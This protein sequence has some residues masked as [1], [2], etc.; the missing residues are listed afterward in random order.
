MSRTARARIVAGSLITLGFIALT[1]STAVAWPPPKTTAAGG[2]CTGQGTRTPIVWTIHNRETAN[3]G[4]PATVSGADVAV[5]PDFPTV[6]AG[7][8]VPLANTGASSVTVTTT[9]PAAFSGTVTIDYVMRW[10][11][12]DGAEQLTGT[13]SVAVVA[14]T[15]PGSTSTPAS[16]VPSTTKK[17][18]PCGP[19]TPS[20][21]PTTSHPPVCVVTTRT[22]TPP[23]PATTSTTAPAT[24]STV[25]TDPPSSH[26]GTPDPGVVLAASETLPVTGSMSGPLA[27]AGVA[28]V[29]AGLVLVRRQQGLDAT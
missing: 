24:T 10:A 11:G 22:A 1:A 17:L 12:T 27:A 25:L 16:S 23:P 20:T 3:P 7:Y 29:V 9:V 14:C 6:S 8:G 15:A 18:P 4:S 19:P 28:L 26:G 5:I 21:G 13:T 2:T